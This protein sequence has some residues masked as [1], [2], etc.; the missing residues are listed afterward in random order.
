MLPDLG[1]WLTRLLCGAAGNWAGCL[2]ERRQRIYF[3]NHT[4]NLDFPALW[5]ALPREVR[6]VTRPVAA[7]DYWTK[8][9][10]RLFLARRVFNALLI[11]RQHVTRENNPLP[12]MLEALEAG[13]SLIVFPE[14]GR[15]P[16]GTVKPFKSGLYHLSRRARG[17]ELI[18]TYLENL[19]RILPKGEVL[20]VPLLASAT[21]GA[22]L[23]VIEGESKADFL[24]RARQAVEALGRR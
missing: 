11:E 15:S 8:N 6:L 12:A 17:V 19:N 13:D 22:P 9:R 3:A 10:L 14:G 18:P 20:P 21:F 24:E 4:S 7:R 23:P 1:C 5:S 2:P 16:D